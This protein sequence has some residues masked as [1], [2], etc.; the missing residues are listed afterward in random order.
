[1]AKKRRL[2]LAPVLFILLVPHIPYLFQGID[3]SHAWRQA[4]TAAVA[5]NFHRESWNILLPRIDTRGDKTGITAMEFPLYSYTVGLLSALLQTEGDGI[6]LLVSLLASL[7]LF[8]ALERLFPSLGRESLLLGLMS[9]PILFQWS[10][11]FIPEVFALSLILWG[12]ALYIDPGRRGMFL[13]TLLLLAGALVRPFFIFFYLP[14]LWD[15]ARSLMKGR[16]LWPPLLAGGLSLAA[17]VSWYYLW[18]PHLVATYEI[19]YFAL[20]KTF[21][22]E[23]TALFL[24]PS[25][26]ARLAQT[27][28]FPYINPFLLGFF[29]L[30]LK[31]FPHRRAKERIFLVASLMPLPIVPLLTGEHFYHHAY[32]LM[33][34]GPLVAVLTAM[35]FEQIS[36]RHRQA[37]LLLVGLL[38]TGLYLGLLGERVKFTQTA[39]IVPLALSLFLWIRQWALGYSFYSKRESFVL[40]VLGLAVVLICWQRDLGPRSHLVVQAHLIAPTVEKLTAS[41]DLFVTND[42]AH[43]VALYI[44]KRKGFVV[45][46][47][48]LEEGMASYRDRG[49][50]W[51]LLYRERHFEL[52]PLE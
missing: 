33:G 8:F 9:T 37:G 3:S 46:E 20:V 47:E 10:H 26:Y 38:V 11:K 1:M 29:L 2:P 18:C 13:P 51:L 12:F 34:L 52:L 7:F 25:F 23:H 44:V 5:R 36:G 43:S 41:H 32:Y 21:S 30:G 35:G 4:D 14:L 17:I 15:V 50:K 31:H 16:L 19:E 24:H 45:S 39:L 27:L 6:G 49:A 48:D 28:F 42:P 22:L 40:G